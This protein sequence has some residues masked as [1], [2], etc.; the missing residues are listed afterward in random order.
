MS[1]VGVVAELCGHAVVA[2]AWGE[3]APGGVVDEGFPLGKANL[4]VL[5]ELVDSVFVR[6]VNAG[7][8]RGDCMG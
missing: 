3:L 1:V 4:S 6:P 7:T 2:W 5:A 8:G